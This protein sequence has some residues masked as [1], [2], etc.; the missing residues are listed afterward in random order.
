MLASEHS[1]EEQGSY[2]SVQR[3]YMDVPS[4]KPEMKT[5]IREKYI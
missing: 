2:T 1:A 3:T 4:F 5:R